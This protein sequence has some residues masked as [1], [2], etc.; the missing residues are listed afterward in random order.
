MKA[1]FRLFK[2]F[3]SQSSE[4]QIQKNLKE[5]FPTLVLEKHV[6][7]KGDHDQLRL[8]KNIIIQYGTILHL[9]G[10]EWCQNCGSIEIGE[11]SVIS[12]YCVIYGC[13]PGGVKI[14]KN[15]D[16]GPNVGIFASRSDYKKGPGHH[17]FA[18]VTI[19]DQVIIF[20]NCVISPGVTIGDGAVIAAGSVVTCDIPP[21]CFA[22]GSPAKIIKTEV[23]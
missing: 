3:R 4:E 8:G 15:F 7:I 18:P 6:L 1:M 19:G 9:G 5:K 11:G 20:A 10:Q 23:R 2:H 22:A 17:I 21:N 14:G 12:P 13:G 16:C